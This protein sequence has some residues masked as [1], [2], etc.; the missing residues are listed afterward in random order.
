[1]LFVLYALAFF[2]VLLWMQNEIKT[3]MHQKINDDPD[4]PGITELS[5]NE[6]E[7]NAIS[8]MDE[9]ELIVNGILYDLVD[10]EKKEDGRYVVRVLNDKKEKEILSILLDNSG[11]NSPAKKCAHLFFPFFSQFSSP[12]EVFSPYNNPGMAG[13]KPAYLNH[14]S[15]LYSRQASPPPKSA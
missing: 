3:E 1:M 10:L 14:Y 7:F 15:F 5:F 11:H 2:P 9:T 12:C 4:D 6:A 13:D 8:W